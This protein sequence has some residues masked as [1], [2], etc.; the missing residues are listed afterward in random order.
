MNEWFKS[1]L[2]GRKQIV[3]INGADSELREL[4]MGFLKVLF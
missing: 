4:N 3:T 2:Q 1:Y